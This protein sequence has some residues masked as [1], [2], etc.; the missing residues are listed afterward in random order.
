MGALSLG[1]YCRLIRDLFSLSA[2]HAYS[3]NRSQTLRSAQHLKIPR[4]DSADSIKSFEDGQSLSYPEARH[5]RSNSNASAK[6]NK[7]VTRSVISRKRAN[8][9]TGSNGGTGEDKDRTKRMSVA[10]WA[11]SAVESVTGGTKSKKNKSDKDSFSALEES[12]TES[13]P[14]EF[15]FSGRSSSFRSITRLASKATGSGGSSKEGSPAIGSSSILASRIAGKI[16]KPQSMQGRRKTVKALYDFTGSADELSFKA[17]AEIVVL[18][19]VL[20]DWWMGEL[21]GQTGLFP[22]S[23]VEVTWAKSSSDAS[24]PPSLSPSSK[25][26]RNSLIGRRS[27]NPTPKS[28]SVSLPQDDTV[29]DN[30]YTSGTDDDDTRELSRLQ[31]MVVNAKPSV[32]YGG[33]DNE[34]ELFT[35]DGTEQSTD[36]KT[37]FPDTEVTAHTESGDSWVSFGGSNGADREEVQRSLQRDQKQRKTP[38][39]R[40]STPKQRRLSLLGSFGSPLKVPILDP[41]QQPL[42]SRSKSDDPRV[43][44][45]IDSEGSENDFSQD[46]SSSVKKIPPPPPPRRQTQTPSVLPPIP[47]RKVPFNA[48]S[49]PTSNSSST[50]SLPVIQSSNLLPRHENTSNEYTIEIVSDRSPFDSVVELGLNEAADNHQRRPCDRF[51]QNPFKTK[52]MCSN[53]LQFHQK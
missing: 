53:C 8:S 16:S 15:G 51:R 21:E 33:F 41:A 31:P 25:S 29:A 24:I 10:E 37:V 43:S 47:I 39:P 1:N 38:S 4:N 18:N 23:Y 5:E 36:A 35:I 11:S 26:K 19:E 28:R 2:R 14:G 3:R 13:Q 52:G 42:L 22:T 48:H 49:N 32:Y 7:S 6:S 40:P 20:D 34:S 9:A 17:G 45:S 12:P 27:N 46:Q 44:V 30:E 50:V